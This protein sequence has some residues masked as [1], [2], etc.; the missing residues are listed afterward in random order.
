MSKTL[1]RINFMGS[2]SEPAPQSVELICRTDSLAALRAAVDQG[3]NSVRLA[4]LSAPRAP[5][6]INHR[7]RHAGLKKAVQYAMDRGCQVSLEID[8]TNALNDRVLAMLKTAFD[9]GISDVCVADQTLA[10]YLRLHHPRTTLRLI[11]G[12]GQLSRR[13]LTLLRARLGI[14]RVVLPRVF[15]LAQLATLR[16]AAGIALEVHAC[17]G[18]CAI[19]AGKQ[20]RIR[21]HPASEMLASDQ[22]CGSDASA[23]ND[24]NF[25]GSGY[26]S[27]VPLG[28]LSDLRLAGARALI[29]ETPG[30]SPAGVAQLTRT[31][32]EAIDRQWLAT[33]IAS[34]KGP[35]WII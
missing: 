18:G 34:R 26:D 35:G 11:A 14:S 33:T 1:A 30:R 19:I 13:A 9:C 32:R 22:A 28:L 7:F 24:S 3:T 6:M 12:E 25:T 15:S 5:E 20:D 31:W 2:T 16:G 17:G 8:G 29:V 4:Y 21:P 23:S 10:L 27:T